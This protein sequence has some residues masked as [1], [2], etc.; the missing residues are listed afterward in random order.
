MVLLS[1]R[2]LLWILPADDFG[3]PSSINGDHPPCER[4]ASG[5]SM[6]A[7]IGCS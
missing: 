5:V 1:V 6:E 4:C 3:V 2:R 7:P